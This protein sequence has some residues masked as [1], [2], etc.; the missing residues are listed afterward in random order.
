MSRVIGSPSCWAG[1]LRARTTGAPHPPPQRAPPAPRA[2]W[3]VQSAWCVEIGAVETETRN[4]NATGI[5]SIWAVGG[6][7]LTICIAYCPM[8]F[9][10]YCPTI[11]IDYFPTIFIDYCPQIFSSY[12]QTIFIDYCRRFLVVGSNQ[13][14]PSDDFHADRAF[15]HATTSKN[16]AAAARPN[17]HLTSPGSMRPSHSPQ[18]PRPRWHQLFAFFH[19][20]TSTSRELTPMCHKMICSIAHHETLRCLPC[21]Q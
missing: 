19:P 20:Q 7:Q 5:V 16:S 11:F 9:I 8:I 21:L 1:A 18:P 14:N 13:L 15:K 12:C 10:D 17:S 3:P 6:N 2:A 4:Q